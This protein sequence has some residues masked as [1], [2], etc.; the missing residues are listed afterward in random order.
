MWSSKVKSVSVGLTFA[1][2]DARSAKRLRQALILP[3]GPGLEYAAVRDDLGGRREQRN[4]ADVIAVVLADHDKAHRLVG[5]RLDEFLED[6]CFGRIVAG[7]DQHHAL[8]GDDDH[9][10]GVV[11]LADESVDPLA[12][13][14]EL[15]LFAR[16][17][18]CRTDRCESDDDRGQD[19]EKSRSSHRARTFRG[20]GGGQPHHIKIGAAS[21]V[22]L[23]PSS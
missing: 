3:F 17:G 5:H 1:S 22:E 23:G 12:D 16:D 18:A 10:V 11:A 14:L 4:S 2:A 20:T 21:T 8:R 13:L 9:R 7:V 15:G 6:A 19:G